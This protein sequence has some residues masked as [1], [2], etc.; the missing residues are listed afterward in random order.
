VV[1]SKEGGL[2]SRRVELAL[3]AGPPLDADGRQTGP[4]WLQLVRCDRGFVWQ[5][6][7]VRRLLSGTAARSVA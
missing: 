3:V 6:P 1:S 7:S 4:P 2:Q 5:E